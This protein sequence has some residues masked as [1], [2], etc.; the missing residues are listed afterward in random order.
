MHT[1]T[2]PRSLKA[3]SDAGVQAKERRCDLPPAPGQPLPAPGRGRSAGTQLHEPLSSPVLWVK[4]ID[5]T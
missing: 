1:Q 5:K 4:L 3:E 2:F